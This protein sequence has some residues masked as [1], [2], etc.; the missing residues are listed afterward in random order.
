MVQF[1]THLPVMVNGHPITMIADIMETDSV[2]PVLIGNRRLIDLN[3]VFDYL[4]GQGGKS[5]FQICRGSFPFFP[6]I[7][8]LCEL[9]T[10]DSPDSPPLAYSVGERILFSHLEEHRPK[11]APRYEEAEIVQCLGPHVYRV[12]RDSGHRI[13]THYR[14]LRKINPS[15]KYSRS[16]NSSSEAS[17]P[18]PASQSEVSGADTSPPSSPSCA[19]ASGLTFDKGE[20]IIWEADDSH[21]RF[22][23]R[24]LA[25]QD[26]LITVHAWGSSQSGPLTNRCFLPAW[27]LKNGSRMRFAFAHSRE[28][29]PSYQFDT[30][31]LLTVLTATTHVPIHEKN[32]PADERPLLAASR[33]K[34]LNKYSDYEAYESVPLSSVSQETCRTAIPLLWWDT[35]KRVSDGER[36]FKSRLCANGSPR[37]DHR[38]DVSVS[39]DPASQWALRVALTMALAHPSFDPTDSLLVGDIENAYLNSPRPSD[40]PPVYVVPPPD[41]LDHGNAL[42]L[43][44]KCVY[45]LKDSE[46]LF[47][48][49]RDCALMQ[50][51]WVKSGIPRLWWK[52]K[53]F[54]LTPT[55]NF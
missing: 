31:S 7:A 16:S 37:F 1:A 17:P 32:L 29:F 51:G 46:H 50:A 48:R 35:L 20:M 41:H 25:V 22:L 11:F 33:T 12:R 47:K 8:S 4:S 6:A 43:L 10:P 14:C 38:D 54:P 5:P 2:T 52:W 34:E 15:P 3:A 26:G 21:K 19:V 53:G 30:A 42:W 28:P 55:P 18:L 23:G 9:L 36:V 49:D 40:A 13:L 24:V 45:G 27:C 44:K 39:S